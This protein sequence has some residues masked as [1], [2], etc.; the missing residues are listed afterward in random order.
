MSASTI[1][2]RHNGRPISF[3][4]EDESESRLEKEPVSFLFVSGRTVN[5]TFMVVK[6]GS[7]S[8]FIPREAFVQLSEFIR[9]CYP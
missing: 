6:C 5:E 1:I 2:R 9:E 4:I 8:I 3:T 7:K